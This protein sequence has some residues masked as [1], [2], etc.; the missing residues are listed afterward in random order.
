M[1][2]GVAPPLEQGSLPLPDP[3]LRERARCLALAQAAGARWARESRLSFRQRRTAIQV[4]DA[5]ASAIRL[6]QMPPWLMLDDFNEDERRILAGVIA[7]LRKGRAHYG[8]LNLA[9]I[10]LDLR[11]EANEEL[12][13]AVVYL[14]MDSLRGTGP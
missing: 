1:G 7:R 8:P 3:V 11:R 14:T 12:L 2:D 5:I 4:S 13:D 6:E 10:R 9:E